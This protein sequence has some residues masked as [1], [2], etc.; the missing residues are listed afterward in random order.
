[1]ANKVNDSFVINAGG[2]WVYLAYVQNATTGAAITQAAVSSISR[3]ITN[4]VTDD[5]TTDALVVATTVFDTA[6]TSAGLWAS[7]Y[8]FKDVVVYSKTPSRVRYTVQYTLTYADGSIQKLDE[9][10]VEGD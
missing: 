4:K 10:D 5:V 1:M 9:I 7:T 3:A 2:Q 8:N 6:Q